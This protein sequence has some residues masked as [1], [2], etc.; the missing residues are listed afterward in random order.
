MFRE[1]SAPFWLAVSLLEQGER[2]VAREQTADA[3]RVL[4]EA[5]EIFE[6]LHARP[7]LERLSQTTT[8]ETIS[9]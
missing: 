6:R 1:L 7:W 2:L 8:V 3:D 5:R 9:A 4:A